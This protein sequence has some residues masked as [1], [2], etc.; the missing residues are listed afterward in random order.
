MQIKYALSKLE[1][2]QQKMFSL[3]LYVCVCV[4]CVCVCV[5]VWSV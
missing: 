4:W 3:K 2:I 1:R 5:C